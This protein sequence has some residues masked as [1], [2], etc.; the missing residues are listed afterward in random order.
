MERVLKNNLRIIVL[1]LLI[2]MFLL[3]TVN[4]EGIKVRVYPFLRGLQ[5]GLIIFK[6]NDFFIK[7]TEHFI[8]RYEK[9]DKEVIDLV[10]RAAEDKYQEVSDMFKY[11]PKEK[12]TVIVYDDPQKLMNNSNLKQGKPPMGVYY[13]STIQIINPRYWVSKDHDMEA[14]FFNE[15]PMIHEF[16]HLLVDDLTRGNYPLWFTEGIAL[17]QEY[18]HTGYKWGENLTYPEQPYTVKELTVNFDGLDEMLA[19]KRS[20]ELV[21]SFAEREGPESLGYILNKLSQGKNF[22]DAHD[23]VFGR[24]VDEIYKD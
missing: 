12:T 22:E 5:H 7:E 8:I 13:A 16:T 19:Y 11:S 2:F 18:V 6:T 24:S 23:E 10:A 9:E 3:G 4:I 17:Y 1:I 21:K 15:G 20:F 14:I